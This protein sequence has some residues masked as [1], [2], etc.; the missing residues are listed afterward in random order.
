MHSGGKANSLKGDGVLS[1]TPPTSEPADSYTYNPD[2]PN[3]DPY[4]KQGTRTMRVR[5]TGHIEGAV[6]TR[7]GSIRDDVLVY[8]TPPLES[9]TEI[10]GPITAKLYAATSAKDTD[11]MVRLVDVHPDGYSALLG[12]GVLRARYRDPKKAGAY[13][14]NELSE[15]V[16]D[17]VYEYSIDFWRVTGNVFKPG[18]RI[19]IEISSSFFPYY[20]RNLNTGADNV[21]LETRCCRQA[22]HPSQQRV[23]VFGR[24]AGHSETVAECLA[25]SLDLD[26]QGSLGSGCLG[27]SVLIGFEGFS[28][29]LVKT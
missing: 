4:D 14:P 7:I 26:E 16:P 28:T 29:S 24:V 15:I 3:P 23:S 5:R 11:W 27:P 2:D 8:Q 25:G 10:T 22:N 17:K 9:A 1:T 18:H 12:E 6:D 20:L 13:N 21:G 19:R